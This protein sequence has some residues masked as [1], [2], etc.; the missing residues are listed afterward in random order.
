MSRAE[1]GNCFWLRN[2]KQIYSKTP[3]SKRVFCLICLGGWGKMRE[4][5]L[6]GV[7]L[8]KTKLDTL[9]NDFEA[10]TKGYT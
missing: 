8:T 1:E 4:D 2:K 9:G 7:K 5:G 3:P 10:E 6:R